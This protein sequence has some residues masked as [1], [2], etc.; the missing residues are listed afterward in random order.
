MY[1]TTIVGIVHSRYLKSSAFRS[2]LLENL[3][4]RESQQKACSMLQRFW[5]YQRERFPLLT[6]GIL[7]AI[8]SLCGVSFSFLLRG[9]ADNAAFRSHAW[10]PHFVFSILVAFG[11]AL[12]FFFQL[13]VADEFKDYQDDL[14]YRPY[15]PVPRGVITLR[16]LALLAGGVMLVQFGL[17]FWLNPD[18]IWLLL[19][20][21]GYVWL[22]R[23]EFFVHYWLKRHA[24]VYMLSHMLIMP[25]IFLYITACDWLVVG[26]SLP[27]GLTWFLMA[28]FFNG[29]IFEIG[30]KIRAPADEEVGVETYTKL[31]GRRT[32][33]SAWLFATVLTGMCAA[34]AARPINFGLPIITVTI[35]LLTVAVLIGENFLQNPLT[36]SATH[37][38]I[39]SS[40]CT[41]VI[42]ISLGL[43]LFVQ[44]R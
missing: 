11:S 34:I 16:E 36:R 18:L 6:Q 9:S 23:K 31:W 20:V 2:K 42:Y 15:R 19:L 27:A 14:I 1:S 37:I 35:V 30:R 22:M 4:Q 25:L 28:G 44:G 13:R 10:T 38:R 41:L 17:A 43:P 40:I 24:L 26:E 3:C 29:V 5:V 12:G 39:F 8:I 21:W 32:A 7:I 33:I